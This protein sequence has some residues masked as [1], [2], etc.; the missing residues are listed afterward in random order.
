MPSPSLQILAHR[1]CTELSFYIIL[2]WV[3]LKAERRC[4]YCLAALGGIM[5]HPTDPED[6]DHAPT[7]GYKTVNKY[8]YD[9]INK[10][11]Y[12][13]ASMFVIRVCAQTCSV[14]RVRNC[15]RLALAIASHRGGLGGCQHRREICVSAMV[16][17]VQARRAR[18]Y[19]SGAGTVF[20]VAVAGRIQKIGIL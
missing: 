1:S 12:D 3:W 8:R 4:S 10:Y 20:L 16:C 7:Y 5:I 19:S 6:R 2:V 11:K 17:C 15:S 14:C 13:W 18:M 9:K